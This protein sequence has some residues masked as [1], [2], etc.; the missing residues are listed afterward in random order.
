MVA[1][2]ENNAVRF[3]KKKKKQ[4]NKN[5]TKQ[6]QNKTKQS[7]PDFAIYYDLFAFRK[8]RHQILRY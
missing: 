4:Q 1:L 3:A 8:I 2:I 5:K 6:K 7:F